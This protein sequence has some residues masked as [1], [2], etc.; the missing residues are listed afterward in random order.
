[1]S[2][3][4]Y[5]QSDLYSLHDIYNQSKLDELKFEDQVFTL[6]PLEKDQERFNKLMESNIYVYQEQ[7]EVIA[8]AASYQNEIRALFV[9]SNHR[10]KGI[11]KRLL[12]YLL[13]NIQGLACLYVASTNHSAKSL[14]EQYGF[15]VTSSFDTTY[16]GVVVTA[17]KM[18]QIST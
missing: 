2:I 7:D 13:A 14:Y 8:F 11:G 16:N 18:S 1:M 3:R 12:E 6:L 9:L 10:G 17:Q 4:A 5:K 15:S